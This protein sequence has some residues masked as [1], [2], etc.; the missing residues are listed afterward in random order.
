MLKAGFNVAEFAV[1]T[2]CNIR[3]FLW[4][5]ILGCIV[6]FETKNSK[7]GSSKATFARLLFENNKRNDKPFNNRGY[8]LEHSLEAVVQS[9]E[10]VGNKCN[11]VKG[12]GKIYANDVIKK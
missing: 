6:L 12:H 1:V 3:E 4:C 9:D 2:K 11:G 10:T 7:P 8:S 5:W